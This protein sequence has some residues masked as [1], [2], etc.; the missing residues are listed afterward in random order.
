MLADRPTDSV[1]ISHN[2]VVDA[3]GEASLVDH[4]SRHESGQWSELGGLHD[5]GVSGGK[6]RADLEA[7][8]QNYKDVRWRV[9]CR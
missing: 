3:R 5:D 4:L 1:S 7:P 2:Q 9:R 6:S 8:H